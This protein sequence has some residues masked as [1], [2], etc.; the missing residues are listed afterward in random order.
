MRRSSRSIRIAQSNCLRHY[1]RPDK[2]LLSLTRVEAMTAS[3]NEKLQFS[4]IF[5]AIIYCHV[6]VPTYQ[7]ALLCDR[8]MLGTCFPSSSSCFIP[9][10]L[11]RAI[12][13]KRTRIAWVPATLFCGH[14]PSELWR[15]IR[16]DNGFSCVVERARTAVLEGPLDRNY[17]CRCLRQIR[18]RSIVRQQH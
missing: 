18:D 4:C 1:T 9:L 2:T 5:H 7:V 3:A 12:S 10:P 17:G 6:V 15:A 14:Q 16:S 11:L 13:S 8:T